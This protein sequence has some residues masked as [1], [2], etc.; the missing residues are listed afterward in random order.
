MAGAMGGQAHGRVSADL[1][2][3]A[4]GSTSPPPAE[5]RHACL[6]ARRGEPT[7]LRRNGGGGCRARRRCRHRPVARAPCGRPVARAKRGAAGSAATGSRREGFGIPRR[8]TVQAVA[9]RDGHEEESK[10]VSMSNRVGRHG[11]MHA[12]AGDDFE[13]GSSIVHRVDGPRASWRR[14]SWATRGV[15]VIAGVVAP[16]IDA[17]MT[18]C[19]R[20]PWNPR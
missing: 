9:T 18:W 17:E 11:R 1:L 16:C 3:L 13:V 20:E 14:S 5:A 4:S 19:P 10:R 6:R 7:M 12:P 8:S 15:V 2:L